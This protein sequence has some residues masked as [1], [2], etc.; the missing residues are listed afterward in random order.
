MLGFTIFLPMPPTV[1]N[2]FANVPKRG[3]V[4]SKEYMAWR[5]EAD[6]LYLSQRKPEPVS[7]PF[8]FLLEMQRPDKRRR[9]A[10]NYI[11]ASEDH[12]VRLGLV[13]DDCDA[14]EVTARWVKE[15]FG[16]MCR[17]TVTPA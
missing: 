7:G 12:I 8:R 6:A 9:D 3:R 2:L 11:K 17:V 1:N 14:E 16:G 10:S 5:R 4:P 13:R 15:D